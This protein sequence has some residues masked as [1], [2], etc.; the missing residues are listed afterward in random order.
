[1]ALLPDC[2]W[3]G[4]FAGCLLLLC[5]GLSVYWWLVVVYLAVLVCLG[6]VSLVYGCCMVCFV[7]F[8]L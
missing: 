4:L 5:F 7:S 2:F 1:M 3:D 8:I 6:F